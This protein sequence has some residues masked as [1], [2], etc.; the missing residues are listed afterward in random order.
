MIPINLNDNH[1]VLIVIDLKNKS[2]SYIDSLNCCEK[3]ATRIMSNV[4]KFFEDF[5]STKPNHNNNLNLM[6][7]ITID[8]IDEDTTNTNKVTLRL[9]KEKSF[10]STSSI[11][12]DD[13]LSE[14]TEKHFTQWKQF[15]PDCPKQNN[16][17]DC[18]VFVCKFM[19]NI[20]REKKFDFCQDDIDFLRVL[21]GIELVKGNVLTL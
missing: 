5:L 8:K 2:I 21:L 7:D 12:N 17:S 13:N 3:T 19:D 14:N 4:T 16:L 15:F 6:A 1:W 9:I 10:C 11:L 18:G 20:T